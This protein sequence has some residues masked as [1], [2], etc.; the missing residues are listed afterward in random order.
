MT[1]KKCYNC[2][3]IGHYSNKCPDLKINSPQ[4]FKCKGYGHFESKCP[5][6]I[7]VSAMYNSTC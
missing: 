6:N 4:C 5:D 1:D 7:G 2:D 3:K